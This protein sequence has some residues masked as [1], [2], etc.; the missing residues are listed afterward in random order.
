[1]TFEQEEL[2]GDDV[3]ADR[4][5]V[6]IRDRLAAELGRTISDADVFAHHH[7]VETFGER[8]PGVDH[9][10]SAD[11]NQERR[12]LRG[13][14]GVGRAHGDSVHGRSVEGRRRPLRPNVAGRDPASGLG[15]RQQHGLEAVGAQGLRARRVPDLEC[16]CDSRHDYARTLPK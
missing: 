16:L 12:F 6:L 1:M 8:I 7:G 5:H 15:D 11:G 9:L 3:L 10:V 2:V 4:A 14:D 13:A